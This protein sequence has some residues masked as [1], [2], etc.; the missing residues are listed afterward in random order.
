MRRTLNNGSAANSK[1]T[2]MP[3]PRANH[4]WPRHSR[5]ELDRDEIRQDPREEH[6]DS[7]SHGNAG[8][9]ADQAQRHSLRQ[10]NRECLS[11]VHPNDRRIATVGS[12]CFTCR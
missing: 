9:H 12:F 10:V 6:L 3:T 7:N 1:L 4:R 5:R 11:G 2:A 8:C